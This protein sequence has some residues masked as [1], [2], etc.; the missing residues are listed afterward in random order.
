[1]KDARFVPQAAG[2]IILSHWSNGN[3]LWSG[4]PPAED[5]KMTVSY[6]QAY[7][8]SSDPYRA[9]DHA[10]RCTDLNAANAICQIPDLTSPPEAGEVTFF[11]QA[12]NGNMTNNQTVFANDQAAKESSAAGRSSGVVTAILIAGL[13]AWVV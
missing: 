9:R 8:N 5:A 1:M 13:V 4:G 2:K 12:P 11:S 3:P 10:A 6:V 7:F